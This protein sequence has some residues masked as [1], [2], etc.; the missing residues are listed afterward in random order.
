MQSSR[1]LTSRMLFENCFPNGFVVFFF[2][3]GLGGYFLVRV[4][5]IV[6]FCKKTF[7]AQFLRDRSGERLPLAAGQ[8]GRSSKE[9]EQGWTAGPGPSPGCQQRSWLRRTPSGARVYRQLLLGPAAP[10]F[11][12]AL[13]AFWEP[14][15]QGNPTSP[16]HAW[17]LTQL[18]FLGSVSNLSVSLAFSFFFFF[19]KNVIKAEGLV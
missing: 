9:A 6:V 17:F 18:T 16:Q 15:P 13:A 11:P 14:G 12:L 2:F 8:G 7:S 3:K 19:L 5:G 10:Q 1:L 4:S